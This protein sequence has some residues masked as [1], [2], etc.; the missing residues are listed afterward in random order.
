MLRRPL[1]LVPVEQRHEL[2]LDPEAL[3]QPT[4]AARVLRGD[5]VDRPERLPARAARRPRGSRS[6]FRRR[7]AHRP[8]RDGPMRTRKRGA[9]A[10][11]GRLPRWPATRTTRATPLWRKLGIAAGARV[12]LADP[13]EGFDE[14]LEALAPLPDGVTFLARPG[15]RPRRDRRRRHAASR[16]R[17]PVPDA[18]R[19]ARAG[20]Q[21]LGRLAEEGRGGADRRRLRR[22]AGGSGLAAGL[23][24]NKSASITRRTSR[25]LQFVVRLAEADPG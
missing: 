23:V 6:A 1:A 13:P 7:T 18:R 3:E 16:P 12:H 8:Y 17:A 20:R 21:A 15:D 11:A 2:R 19:V 24:D 4:R 10:R 14:A 25:A 5:E 22:G 9:G